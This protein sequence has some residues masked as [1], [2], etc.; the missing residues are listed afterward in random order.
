MSVKFAYVGLA[1]LLLAGFGSAQTQ[2]KTV[3]NSS[4]NELSP[5]APLADVLSSR[6]FKLIPSKDVEIKDLQGFVNIKNESETIRCVFQKDRIPE[7]VKLVL[8]RQSVWENTS[9]SIKPSRSFSSEGVVD[10]PPLELGLTFHKASDHLDLRCQFTEKIS[11]YLE[12]V[13]RFE[14]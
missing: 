7:K 14:S 13:R 3:R 10:F 8:A 5:E 2:P 12:R 11:G 4:S 9:G 1:V 6:Y